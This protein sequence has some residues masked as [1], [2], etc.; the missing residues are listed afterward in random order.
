[1]GTIVA[2]WPYFNVYILYYL[3]SQDTKEQELTTYGPPNQEHAHA[4][5][6]IAIVIA[7]NE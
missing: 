4:A 7:L 2:C 5:F 1:M 3:P 6:F